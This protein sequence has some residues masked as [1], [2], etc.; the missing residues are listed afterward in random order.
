MKLP[1]RAGISKRQNDSVSRRKYQVT[2]VNLCLVEH[3]QI[4]VHGECAVVAAG[5][6]EGTCCLGAAPAVRQHFSRHYCALLATFEPL[7][8]KLQNIKSIPTDAVFTSFIRY[9]KWFLE[10]TPY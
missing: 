3:A 2:L 4:D 7:L 6:P 10:L 1:T 5:C 9:L 8:Q